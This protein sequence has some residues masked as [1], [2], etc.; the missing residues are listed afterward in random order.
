MNDLSVQAHC[1][2]RSRAAK[3]LAKNGLHLHCA[4]IYCYSKLFK[5]DNGDKFVIFLVNGAAYPGELLAMMGSSGAG[6]TTL[7]NTLTFR[8]GR[9]LDVTGMRAINGEP[10]TA[11]TLTALSA[12]VQ[13]DDLFIGTLTVREHLIFQVLKIALVTSSAF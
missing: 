11:E 8:S 12:Y 9:K 2:W 7:L 5:C 3:R 1:A 10:A 4:W 13:Q 6:K